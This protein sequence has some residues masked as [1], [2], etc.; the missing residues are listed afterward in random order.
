MPTAQLAQRQCEMHDLGLDTG[1]FVLIEEAIQPG[2]A[3]GLFA[4]EPGDDGLH[5]ASP[6]G[7]RFRDAFVWERI[8]AP[9]TMKLSPQPQAP[10]ALGFSNTK[11]AVK[12]SSRQSMTLPTR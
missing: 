12:S 8:C 5:F 9:H 4:F 6:L 2:G 11:P 7:L 3:G 10:L 1:L